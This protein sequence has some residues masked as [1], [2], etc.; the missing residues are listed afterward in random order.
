MGGW[1]LS[2]TMLPPEP[3]PGPTHLASITFGDTAHFAGYDAEPFEREGV[4]MLRVRYYWDL[5]KPVTPAGLRAW[6]LFTDERGNY[7]R[8]PNGGARF[9]NVHVLGQGA[10]LP[11]DGFP[12]R[13]CETFT[14]VVPPEELN[15]ERRVRV[16]LASKAG[17]LAPRE[18]PGRRF[19]DAGSIGTRFLATE[20]LPPAGN[21]SGWH[22]VGAISVGFR[23]GS[24][25]F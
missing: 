4:A 6:V 11:A 16:A 17:F 20:E 3:G 22:K 10:P 13:I 12:R 14:V 24:A 2:K 15:R 9:Q 25:R 8:N 7:A 19:A 18:A 5:L 23:Q 1:R 21:R